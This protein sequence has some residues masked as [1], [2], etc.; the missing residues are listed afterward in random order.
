MS[1]YPGQGASAYPPGAYPPGAGGYGAQPAPPPPSYPPGAYP[2]DSGGGGGYYDTEAGG[3]GADGAA[4]MV[5]TADVKVR[6]GFLR[7]VYALLT[8]CFAVTV[9]I[10][11]AFSFI[12]PLRD[13]VIANGW[14]VYAGL[15]IGLVCYLALVCIRLKRPWN[16]VLLSLFVL[17]FSVMIGTICAGFFKVGWGQ[18]V[19]NAFISTAAI[20]LAITAY[21]LI[22]K[23]DFS[24]LGGFLISVTIAL[25]VVSLLVFF[26]GMVSGR[27]NKWVYFAIAVA[28]AIIFS[29]Y[30]LYDTS[31]ILHKYGPDDWVMAVASLYIDVTQ[32]FMYM[33][34]I[35]SILQT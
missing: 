12:V 25:I 2:P 10:S 24:Y 11:C 17:G 4:V 18:V 14:I 26:V 27:L 16:A 8:L 35:F 29:L 15:G 30:I 3:G 22:T 5:G 6:L 1:G 23:K 21:V 9:G 32:L 13:A 28:G 19:L 31:L 33:L 20:F 34:Q 7:K